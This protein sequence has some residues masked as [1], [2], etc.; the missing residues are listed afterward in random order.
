MSDHDD[1]GAKAFD[2]PADFGVAEVEH[3]RVDERDGKSRVEQR[4]ADH[5]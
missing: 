2:A 5:E 3:G 1:V 4:P